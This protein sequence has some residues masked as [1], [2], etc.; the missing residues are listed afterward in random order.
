[1]TTN[2]DVLF[3]YFWHIDRREPNCAIRLYTLD[4][5]NKSVCV[6]IDDFLPYVYLELPRD[7]DW[8]PG[9]VQ[10][11]GDKIDDTLGRMRCP[12]KKTFCMREA[13]YGAHLNAD[14]SR[15]LFPYLQC[16]FANDKIIKTIGWL[17]RKD[18]LVPM[19]GKIKLKIHEC[20]ADPVLQL[21][22]NRNLPTT[23]WIV[24]KGRRVKKGEK[25]TTCAREY[26][27]SWE[28]LWPYDETVKLASV[29]KRASA[30]LVALPLILSFDIEQNSTNPSAMPDNE[31]SGDKIFQIS[32]VL[33]R[34]GDGVDKFEKILLSLGDPDQDAVGKDTEIRRFPTE[35][36]LLLGYTSLVKEK[37]PNV[38]VGYNIF[39]YDIPH[40]IARAKGHAMCFGEF[41]KLGFHRIAH[42]EARL[43]KWSSAAHKDQEFE[44]LDAEGR[45]FIDLLPLIKRDY[46]FNTYSL[47]AVSKELLQDNKIDLSPKGIF[48]CYKLGMR[49][50]RDGSYGAKAR[51]AMGVVGKYCIM[52]SVLPLLLM[53]KM[54]TWV[55]LTEMA[56]TY[57][58]QMFALYTAGMQIKVY[59]TV[60]KHCLQQGIVVEKD[61]YQAKAGERYTGAHVFDPVPGLHKKVVCCDFA[62]LYPCIMIA[63]NLDY[64]TF[65]TDDA[66]PDSQ[67][68]I[69]DWEDHV[70]CE[71]DPK[72]IRR[73]ELTDFINA[74][75][76]ELTNLRKVKVKT[77]GK[78]AKA[79]MTEEIARRVAELKPYEAERQSITKSVVNHVVCGVRHY[80]FLK[81][82]HGVL[83]TILQN[84]LAARRNTKKQIKKIKC[85][86]PSCKDVSWYGPPDS[87]P[88]FCEIHK[89]PHSQVYLHTFEEIRDRRLLYSVLDKRQLSYKIACNSAYGVT[90][91]QRGMIPMMPIAMCTTYLGRKNIIKTA[92]VAQSDY[93]AKLVYGDSVTGDTPIL[94][95]IDGKLVY[96]AIENLPHAGWRTYRG[97]KEDAKPDLDLEVWTERGFTR[98]KNIIRHKTTKSLFRVLTNTGVV[99]VTE[100]HGLLTGEAVKVS[101]V[102]VSIGDKLL[103]HD[104]PNLTSSGSIDERIAYNMGISSACELG[105][106][107][108]EILGWE[109]TAIIAFLDGYLKV[110]GCSQTGFIILDVRSKLNSAVLYY[111][112]TVVGHKVR[113]NIKTDC[114]RL[115]YREDNRSVWSEDV[116][117]KI[118]MLGVVDD[119]VY[120]LETENHHFSA[121][122]GKLIVHNTDSIM[123]KF[124]HLKTAAEV[125]DHA[126]KVAEALSTLFPPPMKLE[127]EDAIY[128]EYFILTKKRYMS[129]VSDREGK[130]QMKD[131][132]TPKISKK[133]V[134]LARRDNAPSVRRIYE[135]LIVAIFQGLSKQEVVQILIDALNEIC[136]ASLPSKDFV[137]TQAVGN[138]GGMVPEPFID[139]KGKSK[140]KLGSYTVSALPEDPDKRQAE[141]RHKGAVDEL[142]YYEKWLPAVVQLAQKMRRRGQ[143]VDNGTRLEYVVFD[144]GNPS[145]KKY[146]KMEQIEYYQAHA[147]TIRIDYLYYVK[148]L[149][150]PVDQ[151]L[152]C[153]GIKGEVMKEQ[154]AFRFRTRA[155]CLAQLKGLFSGKCTV[156]EE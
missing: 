36:D 53:E 12:L 80:R 8:T 71:H 152:T 3:T 64:S 35:S 17:N 147:G 87:K 105:P 79:L 14:G 95:R 26:I 144:N 48:K 149:I 150:K 153:W 62:S 40:M 85:K 2:L 151:M 42:S 63:Y 77:K 131:A 74:E 114:Y 55:G 133:G 135:K 30:G 18:I 69:M 24:I 32:C 34:E 25:I 88:E 33:A 123:V 7:I 15:K 84:F 96:R 154:Y 38:I 121:G 130:I 10:M 108:D 51:K 75:K 43:I 59:S 110:A 139:L 115:I 56:K 89:L 101:A 125:W 155:K 60:Y 138:V 86:N 102:D 58:C 19:V 65:V 29:P 106:I 99:D 90:G 132:L 1:M 31:K 27:A 93:Q 112:L 16:F 136:S 73:K 103:T 92:E 72:I 127:F 6:R 57:G 128:E 120:D 22:S 83:P 39:T 11:L 116:V 104:F 41:D 98:V 4:N 100:D 28:S 5:E 68:N 70:S 146:N 118:S 143:R 21:T 156:K 44:F 13:L 47:K 142:D 49:R 122:I 61:A 45:L 82:P 81:G 119:Y 23:G 140:V 67:C 141:I 9:R 91:V 20:D 50:E 76:A 137:T 124:P 66:V 145:D 109:K 78:S 37:N 54:Q 148:A 134:L 111:L 129:T 117:R 52:D 97:E 126:V 94:C 113:L 107:P 46:K